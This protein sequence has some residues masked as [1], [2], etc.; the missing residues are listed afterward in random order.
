MMEAL[1]IWKLYI[2]TMTQIWRTANSNF[3]YLFPLFQIT[4]HSSKS[5]TNQGDV[6][7]YIV[8]LIKYILIIFPKQTS[9]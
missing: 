4:S 8:T 1:I 9:Q 2:H 5:H 3:R 7:Y 6:V